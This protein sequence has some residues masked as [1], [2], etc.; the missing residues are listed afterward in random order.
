VI[1]R[2][3]VGTS[4]NL[5]IP[6]GEEHPPAAASDDTLRGSIYSSL[7]AAEVPSLY[8]YLHRGRVV[9]VSSSVLRLLTQFLHMNNYLLAVEPVAV[10][11]P[12]VNN[13]QVAQSM[14]TALVLTTLD[15]QAFGLSPMFTSAGADADIG[16]C[17]GE[18]AR[19]HFDATYHTL[20]ADLATLRL[21]AVQCH[22][23]RPNY[24]DEEWITQQG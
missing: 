2:A 24:V 19:S 9:R 22:Y 10:G 17:A 8:P 7:A 20:R 1:G 6:N 16:R 13:M 12:S 14:A 18:S 23:L 11:P 15:E 5:A 4:D 3:D 21:L